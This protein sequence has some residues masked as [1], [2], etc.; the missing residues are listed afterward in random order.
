KDEFPLGESSQERLDDTD[1]EL[2]RVSEELQHAGILEPEWS[3]VERTCGKPAAPGELRESWIELKRTA[4]H[5]VEDDVVVGAPA[6]IERRHALGW[7]KVA[8]ERVQAELAFV[9]DVGILD[10]IVDIGDH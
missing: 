10:R 6:R 7:A 4:R 8:H 2:Q 5:V 9:E 3:E 1:L